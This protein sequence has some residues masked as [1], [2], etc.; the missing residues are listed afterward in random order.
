MNRRSFFATV[1]AAGTAKATPVKAPQ[2]WLVSGFRCDD[3]DRFE[4]LSRFDSRA[5]AE[6]Y[7]A[8]VRNANP[9][10]EARVWPLEEIRAKQEY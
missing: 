10:N 9:T 3:W 1:A 5:E 4:F 2:Y 7:A 6:V 8:Q